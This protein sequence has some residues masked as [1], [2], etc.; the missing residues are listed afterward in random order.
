MKCGSD[1]RFLP[2]RRGILATAAWS[3]PLIAASTTV[4]AM[5][6][7]TREGDVSAEVGLFVQVADANWDEPY[8]TIFGVT[9][10]AGR[11]AGPSGTAAYED[12]KHATP[13]GFVARGAGTFT[14]GGTVRFGGADGYGGA[15]LYLSMPKAEDGTVL[16]GRTY[17]AKGAAL[18]V[19]YLVTFTNDPPY[20]PITW[21][22]DRSDLF[23]ALPIGANAHRAGLQ[24]ADVTGTFGRGAITDQQWSG[25]QTFKVTSDLL[26]KDVTRPYAQILTSHQPVYYTE[27]GPTSMQV[28]VTLTHGI[29]IVE[30][31]GLPRKVLRPAGTSVTATLSRDDPPSQPAGP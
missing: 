10:F 11:A 17:L 3:V 30:P 6:A 7:S 28:T 31:D 8:D 14:P 4:P 16:P 25:T 12:R 27:H 13:E 15:G 2:S 9:S 5:A 20:A 23:P 1:E 19:E 18:E 24:G 29:V 26:V 21:A 22:D